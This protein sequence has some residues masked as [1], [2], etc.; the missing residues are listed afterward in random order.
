MAEHNTFYKKAGYYDVVFD[1]EV[2]KEVDFLLGA[3]EKHTG[4]KAK[5]ALDIACGPAY[6]ARQIARRGVRSMGLDL[7]PEMIKFAKDRVAEEGLDVELF[8]ADMRNYRLAK[9]VD[10]AY[11]VFDGIDALVKTKDQ[12]KHLQNVAKNLTGKGIYIID[13]TH[14]RDCTLTDYGKFRY[15]GKRDGTAVEIHWATNKPTFDLASGVAEVEIEIHV[16][17]NGKAFVIKDKARERYISPQEIQLLADL[18][19]AFKVVGWYGDFS[20]KQP[21]DMSPKSRRM[22]SVL[23]KR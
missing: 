15:R 8:A 13:L 6:H 14:P 9:P 1:R 20:L 21:F 5:S 7:H 3:Y 10:L 17:E 12:V 16:K 18:S 4:K 2:S 22:V 23:Q 11:I 19:G